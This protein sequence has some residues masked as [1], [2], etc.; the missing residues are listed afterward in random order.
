ML[1]D[2]AKLAT[3]KCPTSLPALILVLFDLYS[4]GKANNTCFLDLLIIHKD[5]GFPRLRGTKHLTEN[6]DIRFHVQSPAM[7]AILQ[8]HIPKNTLRQGKSNLK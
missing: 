7:S 8:P 2:T 4:Q 1:Q 3:G 6:Q 5:K